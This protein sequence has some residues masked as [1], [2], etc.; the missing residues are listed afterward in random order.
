MEAAG[1]IVLHE[2]WN[3][4]LIGVDQLMPC[5]DLCG[6]LLCAVEFDRG[7]CRGNSGDGQRLFTELFMG[8]FQ[9]DG[10][11]NP[12]GEGDQDGLHVRDYLAE[13]IEFAVEGFGH[14]GYFRTSSGYTVA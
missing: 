3:L 2:G 5:A 7:E 1:S 4:E 6:D 12:A 10:A 11:V 14:H 9:D 8:D 13:R